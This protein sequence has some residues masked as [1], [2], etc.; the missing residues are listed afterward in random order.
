MWVFAFDQLEFPTPLPPLDRLF[1]SNR[2]SGC[3]VDFEI[4]KPGH[5]M[6]GSEAKRAMLPMLENAA[7]QIVRN[8]GVKHASRCIGKNIHIK[9]HAQSFEQSRRRRKRVIRDRPKSPA[10]VFVTI[11]DNAFG[12]SGMTRAARDVLTNLFFA[13]TRSCLMTPG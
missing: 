11:P 2:F 10:L 6:F 7:H 5:A 3:F 9:W 12:A 4:H 1:A 13:E 8:A